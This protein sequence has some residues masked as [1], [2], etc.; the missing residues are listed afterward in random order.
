MLSDPTK[1]IKNKTCFYNTFN[2]ELILT[3]TQSAGIVL[4]AFA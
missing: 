3:S 2:N 4:D 1:K